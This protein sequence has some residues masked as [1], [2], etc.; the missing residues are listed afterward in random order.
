MRY[1]S[2]IIVLV[3]FS[4]MTA[5]TWEP[6]GTG[7][8][9]SD[10]D[11]DAVMAL[12]PFHNKLYIGGKFVYSGNRKVNSLASWNGTKIDTVGTGLD[13]IVSAFTEY[14]GQ[15][16]IGG[17]F[18]HRALLVRRAA[19]VILWNDST[20]V[21]TGMGA[22]LDDCKSCPLFPKV[23]TLN[24]YN[25]E[26]M[27]GGAHTGWSA[28][29]NLVTLTKWTGDKWL[30]LYNNSKIYNISNT[31]Q[32]ISS[33]TIYNGKLYFGYED[34]YSMNAH[35]N[36]VMIWDGTQLKSISGSLAINNKI[37]INL[38]AWVL[39][40]TVYNGDLYIGGFMRIGP[41]NNPLNGI[42]KCNDTVLTEVGKGVNGYV[43]SMAVYNGKLYVGGVFDSAGGKP[44]RNIAVWDGKEW[45]AVGNGL[46]ANPKHD[47]KGN[48][49]FRG[50]VAALAVYKNE[51]YAGGTF[52]F[53]GT[54]PLNNLAKLKL[55][56]HDIKPK[57]RK[58][59]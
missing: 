1:F 38:G 52:D 11:Y 40:M 53:S 19:N 56:R 51:L 42:M 55:D 49:T 58:K 36:A 30:P 16:C 3:F 41:G 9:R 23:T 17:G 25:G 18:Y 29:N 39:A 34:A 31:G 6:V 8:T 44:A 15:L 14:K 4:D 21:W 33:S 2:L 20:G 27:A 7:V 12:Y 54:T 32:Y 45:S 24:V 47:F 37:T 28:E 13:S 48:V 59:K 57:P 10:L 22:G 5:Q 46:E 50:R 43:N 26:L 35:K